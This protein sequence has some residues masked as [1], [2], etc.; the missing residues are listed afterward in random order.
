MIF[1]TEEILETLDM[2]L[3]EHLDIR[4]V[5]VGINLR[6]CVRE[7]AEK[8]AQAIYDKITSTAFNLCAEADKAAARYSIP[9]VNKRVAVT[10]IGSLIDI[11]PHAGPLIASAM[12][13][14]ADK[15]G[16][17]FIGGYSALVHKGFTTGNRALV[18]SIPEALRSTRKVCASVNV[19]TTKAGINVE[20]AYRM[21]QI[22][23]ELSNINPALC[24]RL[25]TFA[26]APPDNPFMA[27]AFHGTGEPESVVNVGI[28][29]PGVIR[30]IIEKM[31]DCTISELAEVIKRAAF[32]ITRVG[33]LIGTEMA[34]R[35]NIGFG[36]VDLSLAPTPQKGDSVAN[37][38]EAMGLERCGA[39]G[40]TAALAMLTDAI[41]KGGAMASS[42]VGGLSGAFIPV[43][44]D[45]GMAEAIGVGSIGL[46]KLEAMTSVCSVGLD[47]V[48]VPAATPA[49][50]IAGII[51][52]ECSIGVINDKTTG[53]RL[54]PVGKE[55][56]WIN[57]GGLLGS[58]PVMP[59]NAFSSS[60]FIKRGGAIPAPL[61]S[62][63]N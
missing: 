56:D 40:T 50:S 8:M 37:I 46:A 24:S 28:S 42:R 14:A 61:V 16:I 12:E 33:E 23:K 47:M 17:D 34:A 62:L 11:S 5:T 32:K 18:D 63:T 25:V 60:V 44:E 54:I 19:A 51:A 53:V 26:N 39:P 59:I 30:A 20:A 35:L 43:S 48:C 15:L 3:Y 21:G 52:D 10:P 2:I 29:G 27:G 9:I 55:G 38:I 58:A 49:E 45:A 57:F 41:K 36:I 7:D 13:D 6:G 1:S 4:T 22:I 31:G